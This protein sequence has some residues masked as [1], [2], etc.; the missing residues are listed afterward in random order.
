MKAL[1][2]LLSTLFVSSFFFIATAWLNVRQITR[3]N[4]V[5][6]VPAGATTERAYQGE[7]WVYDL[8]ATSGD[9]PID[10]SGAGTYVTWYLTCLT[11]SSLA[12]LMV[13]GTITDAESGHVIFFASP[14][15]TAITPGRYPS[16]IVAMQDVGGTT[17]YVGTLDDIYLTV[18]NAGI[19]DLIPPFIPIY[20]EID[21][22]WHAGTNA[23]WTAIA[24]AG[25]GTASAFPLTSDVSAGGYSIT[26]IST[27]EAETFSG[28]GSSLSG[29]LSLSGGT[30]TGDLSVSNGTI[31]VM[32]TN[33]GTPLLS[34]LFVDGLTADSILSIKA[35]TDSTGTEVFSV[36]NLSCDRGMAELVIGDELGEGQIT[37][38]ANKSQLYQVGAYQVE[39]TGNPIFRADEDGLILGD[40]ND[41]VPF[42][43]TD[44]INVNKD[45]HLSAGTAVETGVIR[46]DGSAEL[47]G[48]SMNGTIDMNYKSITNATYY[49]NGSGLTNL[50]ST[51]PA[52]GTAGQVLTKN[53]STDY[54]A[55][56]A[57]AAAT[58][59]S[60]VTIDG[61][62]A[63]TNAGVVALTVESSGGVATIP[64]NGASAL[65]WGCLN[66]TMG[67]I[68][69]NGYSTIYGDYDTFRYTDSLPLYSASGGTI[70]TNY[71]GVWRDANATV[72]IIQQVSGDNG[73]T[74]DAV[75]NSIS[76]TTSATVFGLSSID[77]NAGANLYRIAIETNATAGTIYIYQIDARGQL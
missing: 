57:D 71:I 51:L 28:D 35:T 33:G 44:S 31:A 52:G 7:S 10:L 66:G 38:S 48:L 32:S 21:P 49:G 61:G 68:T 56:W 54:D 55:S 19:T 67:R 16:R 62:T 23:I 77:L 13:T 36:L 15:Q 60:G 12:S 46:A 59:I 58:G 40:Y 47:S 18:K 30:M 42:P 53:N 27:V 9:T 14:E 70:T 26:N 69:S 45:I 76:A 25:G 3:T 73:S 39:T 63:T 1:T 75:T 29:V 50:A 6:D 37:L 43:G 65:D 2:R 64:L 11:N 17:Q 22:A 4:N 24:N 34:G 5:T 20:H 72:S 8:H 41:S 74:W